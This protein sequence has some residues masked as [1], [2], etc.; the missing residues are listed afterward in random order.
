MDVGL[1]IFYPEDTDTIV[2]ELLFIVMYRRGM[3]I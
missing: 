3:I 2:A 1:Y